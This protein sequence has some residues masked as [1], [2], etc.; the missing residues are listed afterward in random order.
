MTTVAPGMASPDSELSSRPDT[1]P[2]D[3]A[4]R[5]TTTNE[6]TAITAAQTPRHARMTNS[7]RIP[8]QNGARPENGRLREMERRSGGR[9][10]ER[11]LNGRNQTR[12]RN[13]R[14][15]DG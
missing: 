6:S 7:A 9:S 5:G 3:W 8:E 12:D 13:V 2:P 10:A 14:G 1:A 11:G 15:C 4:L